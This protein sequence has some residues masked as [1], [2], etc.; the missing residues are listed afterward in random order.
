MRLC[1][2]VFL[3]AGFLLGG[4]ACAAA[5]DTWAIY[6]YICGSDLETEGKFASA[7]LEELR[8]VPLPEN[9]KVAIQTGGAEKW[10][11]DGIPSEELGRYIYDSTG[12]HEVERLPDT[13]MGNG[14]TLR[15]F[16]RFAGEKCPA[17]HRA[18]VIWNHGGGSLGG[19]C[20]DERH[21]ETIGLN[22]LRLALAGAMQ[23]DAAHP[24][25]DLVCFDT[26]LMAS[27]ETANS[28]HG[29]ARYM[30][31]SQ[32]LMPG[33]GTDYAE[34]LG[35][36]AKNPGMDGAALGK[37]ICD[38]YFARC[39][40]KETQEMAT[41]S[42]LDLS[43]LP[44]LNDAYGRLGAEAL[45]A[46]GA[47]PNY[48][49]TALDRV[50]NGVERYGELGGDEEIGGGFEMVDLGALAGAMEGVK[51]A[52]AVAEAI[53]RA[54]VCKA[55]GK[56]RRYGNGISV[57][58]N[59]S[60][61]EETSEAYGKLI[62]AN[63]AFASLYGKMAAGEAD[64][65]P[66][67]A[68]DTSSLQGF[69]V[70]LDENNMATAALPPDALNVVSR[71]ACSLYLPYGDDFL[72]LGS[73]SKISVD[74]E[75]GIFRDELDGQW[76]ALNG[77]TLL[78]ELAEQ[79]PDYNIY[80]S[81]I[82]LNGKKY[83]LQSA[84]DM[85][86]QTFEILGAYRVLRNGMVDREVVRLRP[87]DV[88]TPMFVLDSTEKLVEGEAFTLESEAVLRDEPLP[89]GDYAFVFR[90]ETSHNDPFLSDTV[91]F[92]VKSG[93]MAMDTAPEQPI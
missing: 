68:F 84:F 34:W 74:W 38:T 64:G 28:L 50:A 24:P 78:M 82:R 37:I 58:Y 54:V 14:T 9:V 61:Q 48:F 86:R 88:V 21:D 19:V 10:H 3:A 57:Y 71:A 66:W 11:T 73:D 52:D 47:D 2:A 65:T 33:H 30:A 59:L 25:L 90:F 70:S 81:P 93:T 75:R 40:E 16:L 63:D 85:E 17:G 1:L 60:G 23:A 46:A 5:S 55:G 77:H 87:G 13:S 91:P 31:A 45:Q 89:D 72:R 56:Y 42:V 39:A 44:A 32:E 83:Q 7:N 12:F 67:F 49:F 15:D 36:L 22:A 35:A 51:S 29:F 43:A 62:G 6:W 53:R 8:S 4:A 92:S 79:Q 20:W 41:F 18:L 26:C 80:I 76:P 27:L 69:P